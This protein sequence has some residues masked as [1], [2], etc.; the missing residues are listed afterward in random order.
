MKMITAKE[1]R[2]LT[3]VKQKDV[4]GLENICGL[5]KEAA[6]RGKDFICVANVSGFNTQ[7]VLSDLENLGFSVH[8]YASTYEGKPCDALDIKW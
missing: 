1:A 4:K 8:A 6:L 7:K 2:I 3:E 5:I